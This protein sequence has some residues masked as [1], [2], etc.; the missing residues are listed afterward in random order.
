MTHGSDHG[1]S[2]GIRIR[3]RKLP[4][5]KRL[6]ICFS[7]GRT[8]PKLYSGCSRVLRE[9][10]QPSIFES[11]AKSP[12][13]I[14]GVLSMVLLVSFSM[15]LNQQPNNAIPASTVHKPTGQQLESSSN[16]HRVPTITN[17]SEMSYPRRSDA[18]LL[19]RCLFL[20]MRIVF[21][22]SPVLLSRSVSASASVHARAPFCPP[23][24]R[25]LLSLSLLF[26]SPSLSLSALWLKAQVCWRLA[27]FCLDMVC[28]VLR[29]WVFVVPDIPLVALCSS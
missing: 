8:F 24:L 13:R 22:L 6:A 2:H 7:P 1:L 19:T 9:L 26:F 4:G 5:H 28:L 14:P 11:R 10:L 17:Y 15:S 20:H 21:F 12:Q 29:S 3:I 25:S 27:L 18:S 23:C 16:P